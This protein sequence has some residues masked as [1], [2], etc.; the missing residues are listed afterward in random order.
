[1]PKLPICARCGEPADVTKEYILRFDA[2]GR[3][4]SARDTDKK[5]KVVYHLR[6]RQAEVEA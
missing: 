5:A 6:C 2:D 4:I 3:L 1:M